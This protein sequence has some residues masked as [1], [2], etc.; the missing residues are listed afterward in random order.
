MDLHKCGKKIRAISINAPHKSKCPCGIKMPA[1]CCKDF[2]LLIKIV[3]AQQESK[4]IL[5]QTNNLF[6]QVDYP[7]ILILG[8]TYSHFEVFDFSSYHAPPFKIKLP[9]YL[10]NS[11]FRI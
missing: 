4:C 1:G 2:H 8:E 9:V 11:V 3:D 10:V 5:I 6:K 7:E